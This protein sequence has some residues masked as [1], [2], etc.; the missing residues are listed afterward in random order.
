MRAKGMS[1]TTALATKAALVA[2][3]LV[4][5]LVG[6]VRA[7]APSG[8]FAA[9]GGVV[10]D[11]K[12]GLTWEQSPMTATFAWADAPGH[13]ASLG[14]GWR[15]PTIKELQSIVDFT[16]SA[17]PKI[18]TNYFFSTLSD[19]YWSASIR[20]GSPGD[21]WYADFDNGSAFTEG[22]TNAHLVRCVR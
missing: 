18:D 1:D 5:L 19:Y 8:R 21:A 22:Q 16:R 7:A 14:A 13:C 3:A 10:F 20:V 4:L 15:V 12:T 9:S 6:A 17:S 2:A 11:T